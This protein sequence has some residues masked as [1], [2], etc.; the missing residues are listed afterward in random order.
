MAHTCVPFSLRAVAAGT[1]IVTDFECWVTDTMRSSGAGLLLDADN[2]WASIEI[3]RNL[4]NPAWRTEARTAARHLS[5]HHAF[6]PNRADDALLD[7]YR[8]AADIERAA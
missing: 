7:A 4:R 8:A 1:P 3:C 2:S 6:D 5:T